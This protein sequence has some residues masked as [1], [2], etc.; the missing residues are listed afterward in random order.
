MG[1]HQLT[2]HIEE[3]MFVKTLMHFDRDVFHSMEDVNGECCFFLFE[4]NIS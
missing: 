2:N 1:I 4:R 3:R